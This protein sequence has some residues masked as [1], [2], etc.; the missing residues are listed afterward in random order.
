MNWIPRLIVL[1]NQN[2]GTQTKCH[3]PYCESLD[4]ASTYTL[5]LVYIYAR[6]NTFNNMKMKILFCTLPFP[7]TNNVYYLKCL[8]RIAIGVQCITSLLMQFFQ[9]CF[10]P[11]YLDFVFSFG[12]C[13][14]QSDA[15]SSPCFSNP[16]VHYV[17]K[18]VTCI[19]MKTILHRM[20]KYEPHNSKL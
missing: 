14:P 8:C 15:T 1:D 19:R 9:A 4:I 10:S 11:N 3:T 16:Q 17:Q 13:L 20:C 7:L 18:L 12:A 5:L 6:L 2:Q